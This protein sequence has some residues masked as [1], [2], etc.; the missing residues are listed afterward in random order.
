MLSRAYK[1]E[2][3]KLHVSK[4]ARE[5]NYSRKTL[6]RRLNGIAPK[7]TRN[8]KRSLDDFNDLICKYLYDEQRNF[9][10]KTWHLQTKHNIT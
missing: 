7:K 6:S 10:K 4:L 5:L 2:E 1:E 3:I 9:T 8:R